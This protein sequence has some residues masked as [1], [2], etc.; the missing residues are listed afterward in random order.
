MSNSHETQ[1]ELKQPGT[2]TTLGMA[3]S[4]VVSKLRGRPDPR[5]KTQKL[6]ASIQ[7]LTEALKEANLSLERVSASLGID[8]I[9]DTAVGRRLTIRPND[10]GAE[11]DQQEKSNQSGNHVEALFCDE[12]KNDAPDAVSCPA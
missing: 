2:F 6:E 9:V 12:E 5:H 3:V 10:D 1:L 8:V 4:G 11:A 7:K